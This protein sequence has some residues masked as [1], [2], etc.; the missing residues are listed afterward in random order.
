MSRP[1]LTFTGVDA[2]TPASFIKETARKYAKLDGYSAIEFAI[3]RSPKAGQSPRYPDRTAVQRITH[4]VRPQYLAYHLC[5][6]YAQM[7]HEGRWG[8]LLDIINFD[9][10]SRVQVNS[11]ER[12]EKAMVTLQRFSM[13][14]GKPVIMQ[15]SG[16][17]FPF[18]PRV[19]LLFDRSG[20]RGVSPDSWPEPDD[21]SRKAASSIIG[22]AGGLG[23]ENFREKLTQIVK[24]SRGKRFWVD[25]ETGIRTDDWFDPAKVQAMIDIVAVDKRVALAA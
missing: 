17:T 3:L 4:N 25:C 9:D 6:G 7:V 21:L 5:G 2:K 10:V 12:D 15:W 13:H 1:L 20:G 11:R 23:P 16:D 22:Y 18:V 14:I 8:E 24:A 19:D